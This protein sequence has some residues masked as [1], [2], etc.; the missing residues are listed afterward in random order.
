MPRK[1]INM[2]GNTFN[3]LEVLYECEDSV[4]KNKKFVVR[5][6]L[7]K[8]ETTMLG[9]NIRRRFKNKYHDGCP[10]CVFKKHMVK[11]GLWNHKCYKVWEGMIARCY[12]K[13]HMAYHRYGGRGIIVTDK[14]R[15]TPTSFIKWL[16]DNGWKKGLQVDRENNNGNY[17]PENC[18]IITPLQ[19]CNNT[20]K[21]HRVIINK[22]SLTMAEAA[23]KYHLKYSTV[24][25]R[26]KRGWVGDCIVKEVLI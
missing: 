6:T 16:I 5:C 21:N 18:R 12:N 14:W 13:K 7:C 2:V 23:K 8:K 15:E 10:E 9:G 25:E 22:E 1:S 26:V 24:K 11:H 3:F 4:P 19:N 20:N 17:S